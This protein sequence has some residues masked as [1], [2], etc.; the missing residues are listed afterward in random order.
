MAEN[1]SIHRCT[2]IA[3]SAHRA[4]WSELCGALIYAKEK[5]KFQLEV[6]SNGCDLT[7]CHFYLFNHCVYCFDTTT[8][9]RPE[10]MRNFWK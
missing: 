8:I 7:F 5:G 3:S 4:Q 10:P 6:A 1:S 2:Y 9:A